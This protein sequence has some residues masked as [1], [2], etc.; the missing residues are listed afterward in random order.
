MRRPPPVCE[1]PRPRLPPS[2]SVS[3]GTGASPDANLAA[4]WPDAFAPDGG[5]RRALPRPGGLDARASSASLPSD[6]FEPG[7]LVWSPCAREGFRRS[8][9]MSQGENDSFIVNDEADPQAPGE[10][11]V[12]RDQ[13]R[14]FYDAGPDRTCE[15]NTSLVHLDDAN[16]LDNLQRRFAQNQVYTYTA[17]VLLAVNPYR[18]SN[19][20]YSEAKVAE[21]KSRNIGACAPH[22][23]AIADTA[24]RHMLRERRD[25]ALVISGESGAGKTET[26]KIC[27][28]FLTRISRT[29]EVHGTD[30]QR[31]IIN[32]NPILESFG[33]AATV[34]NRN[35]SRFGKYNEMWFNRVDSLVGAGIKT[36]LL[37]GSRVVCHQEGEQNYHV[38][39]E[40]LAGLS[41][42]A[43]VELELD[44]S[45]RY[46]LLYAGRAEPLEET[47]DEV[48]E[49]RRQFAELREAL[50]VIGF[51]EDDENQLWDAIAALVH[52]GEV[53]FRENAGDGEAVPTKTDVPSPSGASA[54]TSAIESHSQE[55]EVEI[56]NRDNINQAANLL[57][58]KGWR[59]RQVMQMKEV[60][61]RRQNRRTS[62]ITCPRTKSQAYQT[63]QSVIKV[64]YQ[65][66]F[67]NIVGRIN[68]ASSTSPQDETTGNHIGT[69]DIYGFE[70]LQ[71]NSFEQMCINLANERL[72]QFFIEE[73]LDAEQKMYRDDGLK[74]PPWQLPDSQPVVSGIE[75]V[76]RILDDHSLKAVKALSNE[77]PD[78]KFCAQV[79]TEQVQKQV[80]T[81]GPI[82][83]LKLKAS[84]SGQSMGIH[85]GFQVRHYAGEVA[86]ATRGWIDKNN[87]AL[88]PEVEALLASSEKQLVKELADPDPADPHSGERLRSVGREYVS[89]LSNLMST[90][91][92][93]SVHYI[94][95]FNP[96]HH[97]QP[98]TFDK[99][100]VLDQVVQCGTV[101]LVRIMH[102]GFPHRVALQDVR[103]RFTSLLPEVFSRYRDRDFVQAIMLAFEIDETQWT[104]GSSRLFLK[105]GQ[106]RILEHL[107]D[108][109]AKASKEMIRKIT[110]RFAKKRLRAA[111]IVIDVVRWLPRHIRQ[112]R[113]DRFLEKL[114]RILK[115][116]LGLMRWLRRARVRLHRDLPCG[117]LGQRDA[118]LHNLGVT[119]SLP[120]ADVAVKGMTVG[121]PQLFMALNFY[122]EPDYLEWLQYNQMHRISD[123]TLRQWQSQT[124]ESILF[125]D[126]RSLISA[127]LSPRAF[128]A[129]LDPHTNGMEKEVDRS[130]S[131]VRQVDVIGSGKALPL[132]YGRWDGKL[133]AMCQ[134]RHSKQIFATCSTTNDVMIWKWMGTDAQDP[135]KMAVRFLGGM[136]MGRRHIVLQMCFLCEVPERVQKRHGHVVIVLAAPVD[137]HWLEIHIYSVYSTTWELEGLT[138]IRP[139]SSMLQGLRMHGVNVKFMTMSYSDKILVL[140]GESTLQFYQL[141]DVNGQLSMSLLQDTAKSFDEL[142]ECAMVS[143]LCM[144]LPVAY[145]SEHFYDWIVVA[146]EHGK[147]YGFKFDVHNNGEIEQNSNDSGRYRHNSH[148]E[149][150]PVTSL[151]AC[152]GDR[153]NSHYAHIKER[154]ISY[155][156]ALS[157]KCLPQ[158]HDKFCSIGSDGKLLSWELKTRGWQPA[159][160][161]DVRAVSEARSE[162]YGGGSCD[163]VAAHC[164]RLVPNV[165]VAVDQARQLLVCFD[166]TKGMDARDLHEDVCP[167]A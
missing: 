14:P 60:H 55:P 120:N 2:M 110:M 101:E 79:Y 157:Q 35:S 105:A 166:R 71:T 13:L 33:N 86:Y 63:L 74:I 17:N 100:Y 46:K 92:K 62:H 155:S 7:C 56:A 4:S 75:A 162:A 88:V 69:L 11:K 70:R 12:R 98:G 154:G 48:H 152:F 163:F 82:M 32:A 132:A 142:R 114:A 6:D 164:S 165:I 28:R 67:T 64:L 153:P 107:R 5:F 59:L 21:Y 102:H 137:R 24:H 129:G 89:N 146:N 36:Y 138:P 167:Y 111:C 3:T 125:Y 116:Y 15:D 94:R 72:Q 133:I 20:L 124:T 161:S 10:S 50:A 115:I 119:F 38:F 135:S 97:R 41:S 31:K 122:E 99:K 104:V 16:I 109:N 47:D 150:V 22:P 78:Q 131:D 39:Y 141:N 43:L 42:E 96:N 34:R 144:H 156:L 44:P 18:P 57:G 51:T 160:Q 9:I 151:V 134:H 103:S 143:C 73:V 158:D 87:D 25:Q 30:I 117:E 1:S 145:A 29:D 123:Q 149:C 61:V 66:L 112:I 77:N 68:A 139:E 53:E 126:G 76:L 113:C 26:A 23:F 159:S 65:R 140:G 148:T 81:G 83:A 8:R 130:L 91:K 147:M 128:L 108:S 37:E 45:E 84:R 121:N 95:C 106:L 27:M 127:R 136:D 80:S 58:V 118:M 49:R 52:L 85:D 40:M 19:H 54:D 90:L 93:C